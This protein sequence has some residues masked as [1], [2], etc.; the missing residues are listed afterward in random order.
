MSLRLCPF[1]SGLT[2]PSPAITARSPGV[3]YPTLTLLED[4]GYVTVSTV[5]E[6]LFGFMG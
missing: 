2:R 4:L 5:G 3:V 6:G 1:S